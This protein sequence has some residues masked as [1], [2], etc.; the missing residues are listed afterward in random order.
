MAIER[1]IV[2]KIDPGDLKLAWVTTTRTSSCEHCGSRDFCQEKGGQKE[3]EVQA[4]NAL[5]A[6]LGD[7]VVITL[8]SGALLKASFLMY[9]FPIIAMLLGAII[10]DRTAPRWGLDPTLCPVIS[11]FLFFGLAIL[12]VRFRSNKMASKNIYQ[13]KI[14]R[15]VKAAPR[16]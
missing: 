3:M 9:V 5:G 14:T 8:D 11:G 15:I 12:A 13:P 2:T 16:S 1:G 6:R 10:G 7:S 4:E